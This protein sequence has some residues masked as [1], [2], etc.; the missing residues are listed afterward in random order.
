MPWASH[1]DGASHL[2]EAETGT[3][4]EAAPQLPA[5]SPAGTP[6]LA[7]PAPLL[8]IGT[9][10]IIIALAAAAVTWLVLTKLKK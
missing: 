7:Q 9:K 3:A 4:A 10:E 1:L 6:V 2:G 5:E 8:Q